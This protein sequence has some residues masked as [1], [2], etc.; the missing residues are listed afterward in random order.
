MALYQLTDTS[1]NRVQVEAPEGSTKAEIL[2]LYRNTLRYEDEAPR[3]NLQKNL[4]RLYDTRIGAAETLARNREA[5]LLDYAQEVPKGLVSGAAGILESG[6]LGLAALLPDNAEEVVRDGI[7]FAGDAVQDY[8]APDLNRGSTLGDSVPRKLSEAGGSFAGII[9]TSLVNPIAGAGLA[10]TAGMGEASERARAAGASADDRFSAALQ[11]I[12]P[13]A[14]EIIPVSR[15][16]KGIKQVYKGTAKPVDV[17]INRIK[18]AGLEGGIEGA[19][20][21]AS[22][23]AQNMIEQG[24]N[25]T[26]GTFEG[27]GEAAGYGGAVGAIAQA[28]ID[29]ATP[30]ARGGRSS[31]DLQGELFPDED[32][33]QAPVRPTPDQAELFPDADLGQAPARPDE[34]QL[35]LFTPENQRESALARRAEQADAERARLMERPISEFETEGD[36]FFE[37]TKAE[38]DAALAELAVLRQ[39]RRP[40]TTTRDMRDMV[41]E[42]QDKTADER[43]REREGLKAAARGDVEAFEQPDLFAQELEREE[44]RLGPKEL[45]DPEQYMD[46]TI[47]EDAETTQP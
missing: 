26:Q 33:G 44:R 28:L 3:R 23:I 37:R 7:K 34:R 31:T 25:P 19:Q 45:R 5:S 1:G 42:L 2:R 10:V 9:G 46:A 39:P 41:A 40:E 13:G 17:L 36:P 43:A 18:R 4:D 21:V 29:L 14:F 20:E 22:G 32:L 27:S 8:L 11:G 16:I 38:R 15:L 24:Y 35:D 30:R 47:F 6:A 12:I